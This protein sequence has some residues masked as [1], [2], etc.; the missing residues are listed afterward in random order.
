LPGDSDRVDALHVS[1]QPEGSALAKLKVAAA[2]EELSLLVTVAAKFTAVPE[3]TLWLWDAVM[4][5]VGFAAEQADPPNV[6]CTVAPE[7]FTAV[8]VTVKFAAAS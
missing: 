7:L 3:A 1:V 6:I 2:Q 4:V 8:G 5:T